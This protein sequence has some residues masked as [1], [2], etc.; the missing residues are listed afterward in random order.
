MLK[1]LI[2]LLFYNLSFNAQ[3]PKLSG[4]ELAW[5]VAHPFAALKVKRITHRCNQLNSVSELR[6]RLDSFSNGGKADAYRHAFYMAAYAQKIN[7]KKLRK[8]GRVHEKVNYKQFLKSKTEDGEVADSLSCVMD[9]KNNELGFAIG[10]ENK[11]I[12]LKELSKLTIQE[13]QN[14]KA[15]IMKRNKLGQYLTC[16]DKLLELKFYSRKWFVPKCLVA[17]DAR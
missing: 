6:L 8:L 11:K 17:S 10:S 16:D 14:G 12:S 15:I 1:F 5:A 2:V 9:L 4:A 13:I 7:F 3:S